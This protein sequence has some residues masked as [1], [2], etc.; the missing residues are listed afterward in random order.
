LQYIEYGSKSQDPPNV[1]PVSSVVAS[2]AA[3]TT[4][5]A[6]SAAIAV[7]TVAVCGPTTQPTHGAISRPATSAAVS[8]RV[9][10]VV[11]CVFEIPVFISNLLLTIFA[12]FCYRDGV[13]DTIEENFSIFFLIQALTTV[14]DCMHAVKLHCNK[15]F[16]FL[17][18]DAL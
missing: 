4:T 12:S 6:S 10:T 14:N 15:I 5:V 11:C 1:P 16:W 9:S 18:G 8:T 17:I 2:N 3:G 7:S 13:G